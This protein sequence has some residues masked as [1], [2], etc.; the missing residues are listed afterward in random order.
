[1]Q[2]FTVV[3]T[4]GLDHMGQGSLWPSEAW[5]FVLHNPPTE[6]QDTVASS[7]QSPEL[8]SRAERTYTSVI[9]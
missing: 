3:G 1:M 6:M 4:G 7:L 9:T 2:V 8:G 5:S